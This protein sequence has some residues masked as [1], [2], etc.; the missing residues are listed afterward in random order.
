MPHQ[1]PAQARRPASTGRPAPGTLRKGQQQQRCLLGWHGHLAVELPRPPASCA[2]GHAGRRAQHRHLARRARTGDAQAVGHHARGHRLL[3]CGA[4]AGGGAHVRARDQRDVDLHARAGRAGRGRRRQGRGLAGA[5][6]AWSGAGRPQ[7][8]QDL[9]L[10]FAG[11]SS[12]KRPVHAC[13]LLVSQQG[14]PG[15]E[16]RPP[17]RHRPRLYQGSVHLALSALQHLGAAWMHSLMHMHVSGQK[18]LCAER[19]AWCL[20]CLSTACPALACYPLLRFLSELI[21]SRTKQ[22]LPSV[23]QAWAGDLRETVPRLDVRPRTC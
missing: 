6:A 3:E 14:A 5:R 21:C 20:V 8:A 7:G 19:F 11:Q 18:Q 22:P 16:D 2:P 23:R 4:D 12:S 9:R 13:A 1:Q 10:S 17:G 15:A